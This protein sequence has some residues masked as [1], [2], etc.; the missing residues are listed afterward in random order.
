MPPCDLAALSALNTAKPALLCLN[1]T[2]FRSVTQC[3]PGAC[4][5]VLLKF[6]CSCARAVPA[7]I[8]EVSSY[9]IGMCKCLQGPV[10]LRPASLHYWL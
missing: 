5:S 1:T 2:P 9:Q 10:G 8:K 3:L 4:P 7:L 6:R